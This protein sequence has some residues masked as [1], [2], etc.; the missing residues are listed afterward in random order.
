MC[1]TVSLAKPSSAGRFYPQS[2]ARVQRAG[3][4]ARQRPAVEQVAPGRAR[5]PSI[6][7]RRGVA[8]ERVQRAGAGGTPGALDDD[9]SRGQLGSNSMTDATTSAQGQPESER[10][11]DDRGGPAH[12]V[13]IPRKH[14]A[15]IMAA[16]DDERGCGFLFK[17]YADDVVWIEAKSP[18]GVR[19]IDT[20]EDYHAHVTT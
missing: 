7:P 6:G 18:N 10:D 19:D 17:K 11:D 12:P 4:L 14:F 9:A 1:R 15:E 2:L 8:P 20:P 5:L 13:W 16:P 3:G